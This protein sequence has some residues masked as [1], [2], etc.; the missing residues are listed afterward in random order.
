MKGIERRVRDWGDICSVFCC[1]VNISGNDNYTSGE[2]NIFNLPD[3]SNFDGVVYVRNVF[4]NQKIDSQIINRLVRS[5]TPCVCVDYYSPHFVNL[6]SDEYASMRE[7]TK[8]LIEVHNCKKFFFLAGPDCNDTVSRQNGFLDTLAEYGLSFDP[9]WVIAGNFQYQSGVKATD[10]FLNLPGGLPD[11][12]VCS[13]DEMAIGLCTELKRR[14]IQVPRDVR[15]TGIDYD[16]VCRVFSP[17]LTTIKRQQYQKGVSAVNLLHEYQDHYPGE[18]TTSPVSMYCGETCGCKHSDTNADVSASNHLSTD[19]Y[20]QSELTQYIK[21]MSADLYSRK[22]YYAMLDDLCEYACNIEPDELYLCLNVR[23][24]V[25]IDYTDYSNAHALIDSNIPE[26]YTD[27]M[28]CAVSCQNGD[29]SENYERD[30]FERSDLFPPEANGGKKGGTYYFMPVHYMNHNYGY[31]ILGTSGELIRNDFFPN[32]VTIASNALENNRKRTVLEQMISTLDHMWIYDTLTGIYNRAGFFK[33]SEG[34][35][36]RCIKNEIPVCL[37]FIDVDGL[38]TVNDK[39]GHD[40]GDNLIKGISSILKELKRPNDIIMRY[41]GDEFVMLT[42]NYTDEA[43]KAFIASFEA[44]MEL[45]NA[46]SN[47]PYRL[48][49]SIGY[50]ISKLTSKDELNG[51]IEN[52]DQEMYKNKTKKKAARNQNPS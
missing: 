49:A 48:D 17:R 8:H 14:G 40:E 2:Y 3:F 51:L 5:N 47:K 38:K 30:Y 35:I 50:F 11:A 29:F 23:P 33:L 43:A 34:V 1:H 25:N 19:R 42:I 20:L 21:K 28:V 44:S 15:V 4:T 39:Y 36:N 37:I 13:N 31:A 45:S 12:I 46:E 22:D 24:S 32:W 10:Y 26:N 18:S 16:S 52:A 7:I 41:G 9:S 6:V 27:E